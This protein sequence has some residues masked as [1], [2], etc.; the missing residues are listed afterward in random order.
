MTSQ[1]YQFNITLNL[2]APF[3]SH[4]AG[5]QQFGY[6][7]SMLRDANNQPVFP[8]SLI[9]GNLL[10]TLKYFQK[11]LDQNTPEYQQLNDIIAYFGEPSA[12]GKSH[13]TTLTPS[14]LSLRERVG[15]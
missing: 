6:D 1:H 10:H 2:T 3:L 5:A 8:G 15:S 13:E 11:Q 9:R 4:K 7:M 12:S 14:P